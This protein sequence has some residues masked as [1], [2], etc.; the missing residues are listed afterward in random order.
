MTMIQL[1]STQLSS[2]DTSSCV[3]VGEALMSG[4]PLEGWCEWSLIP[5]SGQARVLINQ[6]VDW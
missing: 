6:G 4:R 3:L 2:I 1:W 5:G